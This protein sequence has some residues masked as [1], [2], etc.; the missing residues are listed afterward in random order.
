MTRTE[1]AHPRWRNPVH[2]LAFGLGAGAM[3]FAPGTFGTL[4]ALP[5]YLLMRPL[6]AP[7]YG[8]IVIVFFAA[9]IWLCGTTARQLEVH[10]HPGIVWDEIVGF[11]VTMFMAPAGWIPIVAGFVLFRLFDIW[12]PFPIC[13][14][15][16]HVKGGLGIMLDDLAA[17]VAAALVLNGAFWL[18]M[19]N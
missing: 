7:W 10:D 6:A 4:A 14:L 5:L 17:G 12:K 19:R 8:L 1:L 16:N 9:G 18:W 15:D 13:W 2:L 11:L 3:P